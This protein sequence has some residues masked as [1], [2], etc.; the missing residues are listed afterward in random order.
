MKIHNFHW[1][2]SFYSGNTSPS[3]DP[4]MDSN[5][6]FIT[7]IVERGGIF[8]SIVRSLGKTSVPW[9]LCS[10][11]NQNHT[12]KT[13]WSSTF[14]CKKAYD[15]H[16]PHLLLSIWTGFIY[17]LL[18]CKL[19]VQEWMNPPNVCTGNLSNLNGMAVGHIFLPNDVTCG[20][21]IMVSISNKQINMFLANYCWFTLSWPPSLTV[22]ALLQLR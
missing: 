11:C 6:V 18:S 8:D 20:H 21:H 2:H 15:H 12:D 17:R 7:I 9:H 1:A 14:L 4:G 22:V 16:S 19:M 5:F 13:C 10:T 3:E